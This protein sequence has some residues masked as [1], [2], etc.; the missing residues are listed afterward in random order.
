MFDNTAGNTTLTTENGEPLLIEGVPFLLDHIAIVTKARGSKGVWDKGGEPAGVLLTNPEVSDMTEKVNEPKADAQGDKLDAILKAV[1]SIAA[2][3]DEMEKNLPAPPLVTAA[4]KK[5][6]DD[7]DMACDDDDEEESESKAE[8]FMERKMDKKRKD[9]DDDSKHRKDDDEEDDMK[10]R[11]DAKKRKDAEGSNPKEHDEGEIKPDDDDEEEMAKKAD[12]EA[13]EYADAQA[14]ADSVFASFGKSAS[15]P[16]AGEGL[17]AYRKRLLRG[18]QAYSDSFKDVNINSIKDAKLLALTEKQIFADA[19]AASKS[20]MTYAAD[21]EIAIQKKDSAGRT[22]TSFRG[23]MGWLD[24]FKVPAMR[25]TKFH[26]M[27][28]QR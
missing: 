10:H 11:K 15:R 4:D 20:P 1:G 23:G 13:A 7:D 2:R 3:V 12:D 28:N 14:K 27:N 24:A 22:I 17:M 16:L 18:L 9:D 21:Q 19:L 6:K 5:R 8:K 26:T 25:V